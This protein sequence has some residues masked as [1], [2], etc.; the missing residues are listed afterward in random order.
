MRRALLLACCVALSTGSV[1]QASA[2]CGTHWVGA[3]A[4]VPSD[5]SMGTD[6][7]DAF[8]PS[9][10][11]PPG[12]AGDAKQPVDNASIRAIL[13]PSVGGS[14]VRVR[15]SNRFGSGP[16]TLNH[17]TIGKQTA[18]AELAA[19]PVAVAF[20]GKK[21]VTVAAGTDAVSDS[22][23]FSY[24]AF[25]NLAVSTYV[26]GDVG[27][28]TE[29]Y[30]ARQSSFFTLNGAGDH[31]ADRDGTAYSLS[32]T[33]RPFVTGLDVRAGKPLGAVVT[34]GDSI[35]DGYQGRA[36][37]GIPENP[38]GVDAN[39]RWPDVL[40]RRLRAARLPLSVVN[41]AISGNRVLRDGTEGGGPDT[42]GPAALKRLDADVLKQAGATTV[43][44]FEGINDLGQKPKPTVKDVIGG[45]TR[46]IARMHKAGLRVVQGTLTPSGGTT[47]DYGTAETEAK[48]QEINAWIRAKSAA[49]GVVDFDAAV[50]DPSDPTRIDPQYDGGDHLHFN[51][52][53][54]KKMGDTVDLALLRRPTC[55]MPALKLH[56]GPRTVRRGR[57]VRV[58]FHVTARIG[59]RRADVSAA[60]VALAGHRART[61][62]HGRAS[63]VLRFSRVGTRRA[64]ASAAGYR[65]ATARLRVRSAKHHRHRGGARFAG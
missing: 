56:L 52:A 23:S 4:G 12:S 2:V 41:T 13:T 58:R 32:N 63:I 62:A 33:T 50:R 25:D 11:F 8:A 57:R 30:T 16:V 1:A 49:D 40:G 38:E 47:N 64:R 46:G 36:P 53:G 3:W 65:P 27:K 48:R 20:G 28:P 10:D 24:N 9:P 45:Y 21:S 6:I 14:T 51:L 61:N 22:V 18:A 60:T 26:S 39:G 42:Y 29:H 34:F 43:I 35:T 44:W 5:S 37:A 55:T 31:A 19:T 17:T 15:L 7:G 59:R 54:Y